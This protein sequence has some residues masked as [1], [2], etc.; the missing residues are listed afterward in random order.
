MCMHSV[1]AVSSFLH[2]SYHQQHALQR[3]P[4]SCGQPDAMQEQLTSYSQPYVMQEWLT[5]FT[6][7]MFGKPGGVFQPCPGDPATVH[8]IRAPERGGGNEWPDRLRQ[9]GKLAG[10]LYITLSVALMLIA[11]ISCTKPI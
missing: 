10:R 3:W 5:M 11:C 9:A 8:P 7:G 2:V 4:T 6:K 1:D